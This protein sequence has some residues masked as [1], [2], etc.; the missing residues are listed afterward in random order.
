M[1]TEFIPIDNSVSLLFTFSKKKL[2][3]CAL[4][5]N[6]L[7]DCRTFDFDAHSE[8]CHLWNAD[9]TTGSIVPS[10]SKPLSSVATI[11]LSSNIYAN[12]HNQSCDKCAQSRY[13]TC[14]VYSNTCQCPSK[15]FWNGSMC[16]LQLFQDQICAQADACRSDLN[17][18]CQPS[19]DFTYRCSFRK[20]VES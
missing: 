20:S 2:T 16:L 1:G 17:L 14:D 7:T 12:I 10:S 3:Y 19:C 4:E 5:C 6:K 11:R 8:Q 9:L 13:E 18:T 15:T